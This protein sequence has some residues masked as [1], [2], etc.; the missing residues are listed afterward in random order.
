MA[1]RVDFA[2]CARYRVDLSGFKSVREVEKSFPS[3]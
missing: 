1:R 2:A 3:G